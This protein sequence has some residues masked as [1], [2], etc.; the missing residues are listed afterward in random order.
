MGDSYF[1]GDGPDP[2]DTGTDNDWGADQTSV[3]GHPTPTPQPS[4][5]GTPRPSHLRGLQQR[6]DL[7]LPRLCRRE[8][9]QRELRRSRPVR[10]APDELDWRKLSEA[11]D[12]ATLTIGGNDIGF[13]PVLKKCAAQAVP[14]DPPVRLAAILR[15]VLEV[16]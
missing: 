16:Q 8:D 13:G 6:H 3:T 1:S 5:S 12:L 15:D 2:Y 7:P 11:T 14:R 4:P 10:R 9:G